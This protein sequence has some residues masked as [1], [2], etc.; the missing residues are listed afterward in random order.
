MATVE[1]DKATGEK[2]DS[3]EMEK[4]EAKENLGG[5]K[6]RYHTILRLVSYCMCGAVGVEITTPTETVMSARY[7]YARKNTH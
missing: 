5:S 7:V 3:D 6:Y 1:R 4:G 2:I